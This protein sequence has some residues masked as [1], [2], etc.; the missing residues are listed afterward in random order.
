MNIVINAGEAIGDDSGAIDLMI[1]KEDDTVVLSVCDDGCGMD[2]QTRERL[3]EP[4]YTTKFTGRG[5]GLSAVMG[6]V[7]GHQGELALESTLGEGTTIEI[8]LATAVDQPVEVVD[9][10]RLDSGQGMVLVVDDEQAVRDVSKGL[11][12]SLGYGVDLANDGAE[13][14]RRVVEGEYVAL[15]VDLVMPKV[16][17]REVLAE[18]RKR[19]PKL[20]VILVSGYGPL[21]TN[22]HLD[23][24]AYTSFLGKP[25]QRRQL[26]EALKEFET[27]SCMEMS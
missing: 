4:F 3:F 14:L 17:G 9:G 21:L 1:R 11:L 5:L 15:I 10:G 19:H 13:A 24:D 22:E 18:V 8:R 25:F 20:P 6:I 16:D 7:R 27:E 2:K 23:A 26:A 12:E